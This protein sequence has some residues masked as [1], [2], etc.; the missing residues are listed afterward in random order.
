MLFNHNDVL[1]KLFYIAS[2]NVILSLLEL[3]QISIDLHYLIFLHFMWQLVFLF[4][5]QQYQG[6][7]WMVVVANVTMYEMLFI[8]FFIIK[9]RDKIDI[10]VLYIHQ[11]FK[12][13]AMLRL[14]FDWIQIGLHDLFRVFIYDKDTEDNYSFAFNVICL[15]HVN[16]MNYLQYQ[17]QK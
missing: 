11:N 16:L 5:L 12:A 8:S 17:F 15:L 7:Q 2:I 10:Y 6:I 9:F 13:H 3:L 4:N 1:L 14:S